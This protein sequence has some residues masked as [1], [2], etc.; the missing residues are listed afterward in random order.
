LVFVVQ[1]NMPPAG[2]KVVEF[3]VRRIRYADDTLRS[4]L[5]PHYRKVAAPVPR[6][7]GQGKSRCGW[8]QQFQAFVLAAR[9]AVRNPHVSATHVH[10]LGKTEP[11][12]NRH[13]FQDGAA[14][15][16]MFRMIGSGDALFRANRVQVQSTAAGAL[17]DFK[18]RDVPSCLSDGLKV[19]VGNAY[20][21]CVADDRV[22]VVPQPS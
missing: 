15:R 1:R 3:I 12:R 2:Y 11:G 18:P 13:L 19:F 5:A 17:A 22:E 14:E 7:V 6:D 21:R 9:L 4:V 20:A 8:L 10:A 16:R